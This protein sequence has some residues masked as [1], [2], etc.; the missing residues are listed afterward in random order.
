M[1]DTDL[2]PDDPL[3][4]YTTE[5]VARMCEVTTETVRAWLTKGELKGVRLN[6]YWRVMRKDLQEF[7]EARYG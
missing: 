1:T 4:T 7:L 3:Q 5:Q 2:A 6:G